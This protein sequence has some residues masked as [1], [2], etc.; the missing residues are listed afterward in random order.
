M[1]SFQN[2]GT[3]DLE[4]VLQIVKVEPSL[5]AGSENGG[6]L[7]GDTKTGQELEGVTLRWHLQSGRH[8]N[9]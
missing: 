2:S 1:S 8:C 7:G 3:S 4:G 9:K 5:L 6:E